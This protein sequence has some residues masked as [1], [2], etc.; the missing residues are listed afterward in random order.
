MTKTP[1][2]KEIDKRMGAFNSLS[3]RNMIKAHRELIVKMLALEK[4]AE[5]AGINSRNAQNDRAEAIRQRD[6]T[7]GMFDDLKAK[8]HRSEIENARK[9]GILER[10]RADDLVR[11]EVITVERPDGPPMLVPKRDI[12]V[13]NAPP[14]MNYD[15]IN[16]ESG[17]WHGRDTPAWRKKHWTAY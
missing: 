13:F 5:N 2:Q 6:E 4:T 17:L 12:Q 3:S 15:G 11:E 7:R 14:M 1:E 16:T 9:E 10:V 8:L